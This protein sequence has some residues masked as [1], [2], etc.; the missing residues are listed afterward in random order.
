M[1]D[2]T[3]KELLIMT[4]GP[5]SIDPRV[6]QAMS[7]RILGQFDP[8]FLTIMDDT[9]ELTRQAFETKNK[10]AFDLGQGPRS[11]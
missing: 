2:L 8:D 5:V 4:P 9:M 10:W 7:N 1:S 11:G 3:I 6:S